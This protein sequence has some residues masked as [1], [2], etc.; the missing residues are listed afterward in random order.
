LAGQQSAQAHSGGLIPT[1]GDGADYYLG[2]IVAALS[3]LRKQHM[4]ALDTK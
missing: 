4:P 3:V 1:L 2:W